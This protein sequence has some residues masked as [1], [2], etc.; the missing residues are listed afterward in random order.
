MLKTE[1]KERQKRESLKRHLTLTGV[2][3]NS[4]GRFK[5]TQQVAKLHFK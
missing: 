5:A 2:S 4:S 3:V 1:S